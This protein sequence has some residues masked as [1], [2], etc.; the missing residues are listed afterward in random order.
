MYIAKG[1]GLTDSVTGQDQTSSLY[2]WADLSCSL[3]ERGKPFSVMGTK[4]CADGLGQI[5][6]MAA[7]PVY[8]KNP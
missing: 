1:Q 8:G 2:N 7:M 6:M 5:N 3:C 4:V